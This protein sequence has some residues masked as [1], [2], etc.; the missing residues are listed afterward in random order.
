MVGQFDFGFLL[1]VYE[2]SGS[3]ALLGFGGCLYLSHR[4]DNVFFNK[5]VILFSLSKSLSI[6]AYFHNARRE[7][8]DP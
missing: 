2:D 5:I 3:E 4:L 1:L 8:V 6:P 7:R